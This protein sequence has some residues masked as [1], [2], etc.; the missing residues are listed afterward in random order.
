[1][2][3][4]LY[5]CTTWTLTKHIEKQLLLKN[6]VCCLEQIVETTPHKM[7][8]VWPLISYL[9]NHSNKMNKMC[10]ALLEKQRQTYK[11]CPLT[12][13]CT[14]ICQCWPTS[15]DLHHLCADTGCSLEALLGMD[16]ERERE[17]GSRNSVQLAGFD[18]SYCSYWRMVKTKL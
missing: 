15:K 10:R 11:W 13:F 9:T 18:N 6:A 5:R 1:M 2:S 8:T 4:L 17:R 12:D 7:V 16:S 3:I 14:W